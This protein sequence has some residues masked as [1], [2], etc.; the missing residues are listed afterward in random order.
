MGREGLYTGQ[1]S[2]PSVIKKKQGLI[3]THQN[4]KKKIAKRKYM[5]ITLLIEPLG[6]EKSHEKMETKEKKILED[7]FVAK[8]SRKNA[9]MEMSRTNVRISTEK[10]IT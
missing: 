4:L 9:T 5:Y 3:F 6:K 7:H 8:I 1:A 10:N 2:R